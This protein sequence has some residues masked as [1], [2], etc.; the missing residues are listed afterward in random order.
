MA[1]ADDKTFK[2][3]MTKIDESIDVI[4]GA[5]YQKLREDQSGAYQDLV[6]SLTAQ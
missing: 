1:L 2:N 3:L 5:D 4:G 6:K